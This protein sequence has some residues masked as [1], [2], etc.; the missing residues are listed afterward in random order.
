VKLALY[1]F[2]GGYGFLDTIP[3]HY[4]H[5]YKFVLSYIQHVSFHFT[6]HLTDV[7]F[8]FCFLQIVEQ[9]VT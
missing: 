2:I 1:L 9:Y 8:N 6:L 3:K 7:N 5:W 4:N